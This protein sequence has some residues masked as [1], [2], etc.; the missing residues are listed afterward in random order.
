MRE[1]KN[2]LMDMENSHNNNFRP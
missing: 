1:D 2:L